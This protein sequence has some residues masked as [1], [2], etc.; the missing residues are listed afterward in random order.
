MKRN[1]PVKQDTPNIMLDKVKEYLASEE[2]KISMERFTK[3][4]ELA[5]TQA[6]S[7]K[8]RMRKLFNGDK[9]S[10]DVLMH[11]II[12]KHN[13]AYINRWFNKGCEPQPMNILYAIH[14]VADEDGVDHLPIDSFTK[15]F[16]SDVVTFMNWQFAC[17]QGQSIVTSV[18]KNKELM[19]R[20]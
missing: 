11:K 18:Y 12:D 4:M 1:K 17:T 13:E 7:N 15:R 9:E 14:D 3:E 19:L 8:A 20:M 2:G 10:F 16:S 5:E 6:R